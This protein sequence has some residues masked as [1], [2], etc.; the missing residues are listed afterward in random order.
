MSQPVSIEG[1]ELLK[2]TLVAA[3]REIE[4]LDQSENTRLVQQRAQARAPK[5]SGRLSHSVTARDLGKGEGVVSSELV[6]APVIHY[7]WA[8]H[9]I[10]PQPFLTTALDDSTSL[11]EAN[12]LRQVNAALNRV[13][14][15]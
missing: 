13:K 15:A 7:G 3:G 9:H 4:N 6:Y 1:D 14:G 11:I 10:S 5:R 8:A 2:L 12:D